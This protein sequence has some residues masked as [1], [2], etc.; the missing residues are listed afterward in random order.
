MYIELDKRNN[1]TRQLNAIM[2]SVMHP[3]RCAQ[4]W[5]K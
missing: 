2:K 4:V 3:K 1:T 5:K